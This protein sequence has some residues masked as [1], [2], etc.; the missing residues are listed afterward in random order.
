MT[1]SKNIFIKLTS[2]SLR[3]PSRIQG[4]PVGSLI[5]RSGAK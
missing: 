1:K 2:L 3:P 4:K 5:I